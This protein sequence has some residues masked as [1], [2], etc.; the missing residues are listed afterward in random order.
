MRQAHCIEKRRD[1]GLLRRDLA[2][3]PLLAMDARYALWRRRRTDL[4]RRP[5]LALDARPNA[6][7]ARGVDLAG[8]PLLALDA[9]F[10][11]KRACCPKQGKPAL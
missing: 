1:V 4:A 9:E 8:R 5:S 10:M 11:R 3:R 2:G 7:G 6:G